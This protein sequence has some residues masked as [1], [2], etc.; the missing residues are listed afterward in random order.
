M[1]GSSPRM[2]RELCSLRPRLGSAPLRKSYALRCVRGTTT[3]YFV[4]S[5]YAPFQ[6]S[7]G[8][9]FWKPRIRVS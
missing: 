3:F 8:G 6:S 2:T 1:G 5:A 9:S 4:S 7:G